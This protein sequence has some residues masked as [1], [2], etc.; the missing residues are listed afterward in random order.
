MT[1]IFA[2]IVFE[3]NTRGALKDTSLQQILKACRSYLYPQQRQGVDK[4]FSN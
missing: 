2:S 4:F 1:K 3:T